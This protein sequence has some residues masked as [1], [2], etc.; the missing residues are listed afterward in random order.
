MHFGFISTTFFDICLYLSAPLALVI[1]DNHSIRKR[2]S[3]KSKGIKFSTFSTCFVDFVSSSFFIGFCEFCEAIWRSIWHN[4]R[5]KNRSENRF[6]KRDPP[7][8]KLH[9]IPVSDGPQRRHL[10]C[11]LLNSNNSSIS[12]SSSISARTRIVARIRVQ[13]WVRNRKLARNWLLE[14]ASIAKVSKTIR[15]NGKGWYQNSILVIWHAR[16]PRARRIY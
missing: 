11:A 10:A 16:W 7:T 8:W 6:K 12:N 13:V 1:F 5:E 15:K 14:L 4:F 9:P 2:V 3:C